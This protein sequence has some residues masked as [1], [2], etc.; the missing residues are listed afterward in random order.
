MIQLGENTLAWG[1][2]HPQPDGRECT[3]LENRMVTR[4]G[5][6]IY[7]QH[8]DGPM[9]ECRGRGLERPSGPGTQP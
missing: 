2:A 9:V 4:F 1:H 5:I 3:Q 7:V 8:A 6:P